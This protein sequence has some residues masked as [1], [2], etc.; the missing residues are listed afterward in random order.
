VVRRASRT[1]C[2]LLY[3][4]LYTCLTPTYRFTRIVCRCRI[5][6]TPA[7]TAMLD[8]TKRRL[9]LHRSLSCDI[10]G[11]LVHRMHNADSSPLWRM[12]A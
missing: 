2:P 4:L 5:L 1:A 3:H 6:P 11:G 7:Y 9:R 8:V 10:H 12:P